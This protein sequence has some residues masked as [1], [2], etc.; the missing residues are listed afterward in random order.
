MASDTAIVYLDVDDEITSAATRIRSAEA[1]RIALVLPP[2]SRLATS[3][4]NFRL[5]ARE[6]QARSRQLVIVAPEAAT[7]A[8]AASAGI[9]AYAAVRDLDEPDGIERHAAIAGSRDAA[10][11][12]AYVGPSPRAGGASADGHP[13]AA[14]SAAPALPVVGGGRRPGVGVS[15]GRIA[16]VLV[17][18]AILLLAIV[19]YVFLPAATIVVTPRIDPL[20]PLTFTVRA[21][22]TASAPD[23]ATGVV[24]AAVPTFPLTASGTF[25]SSGKK[26]TNTAATGSVTFSNIDPFAQ[27]TIAAGS[28][29]ST[30]DGIGFATTRVVILNP[31][32][33]V[34]SGGN[35][36]IVPTT[37]SSPVTAVAGG[38]AGNVGAGAIRIP[39]PDQNARKIQ[40]RNPAPTSGGSHTEALIIAQKDIDAATASLTTQLT[41]QLDATIA[42]PSQV[43]P[44]S[45]VFPET[46]AM[47]AATPTVDPTTLVGQQV[48]SFSYGL[49]ATG[50]VTAVDLAAVEALATAQLSSSV[51]ADHT[52]VA[53]S[54]QVTVGKGRLQAGTIVFAVRATAQEA[55][56]L[57][58]V[59]LLAL[60]KGRSVAE[61]E[62]ALGPYGTASITLWPGFTDRVPDYDFRID[63]R[64]AAGSGSAGPGGG[65]AT[66]ASQPPAA[67]DR[68][69]GGSAPNGI[70]TKV[71]PANSPA[72]SMTP[73]VPSPSA[74]GSGTP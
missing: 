4:I 23:A 28:V 12:E 14:R 63:L 67:T 74:A 72:P 66:P 65:G 47:T 16:A 73:S 18:V 69:S 33:L 55:R 1:P 34:D 49:T 50:S 59:D 71:P 37:G 61:A 36:V 48:T 19:G 7:R 42:D 24:P 53:G 29:V 64:I 60:V 26:V 10:S 56:T 32:Q 70:P 52:L 40:V 57:N 2:G 38:T 62:V 41:A 68:P 58:G 3:R 17:G 35:I 43:L 8:L 6:A 9:D 45:T 25:P 13:I 44:G 27:H 30:P 22:P 46:K 51:A 20:G 5:L 54:A 21:D 11:A 31:A 39:P 15:S